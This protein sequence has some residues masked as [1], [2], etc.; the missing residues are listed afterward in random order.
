ME[1]II[2]QNENQNITVENDNIQN[3]NISQN[4]NVFQIINTYIPEEVPDDKPEDKPDGP[5][6][7]PTGDNNPVMLYA[8]LMSVSGLVLLI[9]GSKAEKR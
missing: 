4:E 3:I 7:T 9:M 2:S 5:V 8:M 1:I 6:I